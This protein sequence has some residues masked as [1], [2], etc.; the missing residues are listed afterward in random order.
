[1]PRACEIARGSF[2]AARRSRY[3]G[4]A[5]APDVCDTMPVP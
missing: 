5:D 2:D 4:A 3:L 1:V